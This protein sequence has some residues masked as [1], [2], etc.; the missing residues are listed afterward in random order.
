VVKPEWGTKRL[1]QS[2]GAKFYDLQRSPIVCPACGAT[3]DLESAARPKRARPAAA[4][5]VPV[6]DEPPAKPKKKALVE[7]EVDVDEEEIATET[8][9]EETG[10]PIEDASELG[11]DDDMSDVI[12]VE[13]DEDDR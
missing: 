6:E 8:D 10:S 5:P 12:D 7:D 1:C 11:E 4:K 13:D 3:F 2:C 9:D